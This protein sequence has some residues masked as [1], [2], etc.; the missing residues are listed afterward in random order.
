MKTGNYFCKIAYFCK[1]E[2]L[3]LKEKTRYNRFIVFGRLA[4][5]GEHLVYTQVVG[6]SIPSSSNC[7]GT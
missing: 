3:T 5:L 1:S 2:C 6:G 4:Q 7:F